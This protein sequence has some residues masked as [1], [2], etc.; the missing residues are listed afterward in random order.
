MKAR[1][2]ATLSLI[3]CLLAGAAQARDIFV[4]AELCEKYLEVVRTPIERVRSAKGAPIGEGASGKHYETDITLLGFPECQM[5][6]GRNEIHHLSCSKSFS[7]N[8]AAFDFMEAV[9]GCFTDSFTEVEMEYR[10]VGDRY[11]L[12]AFSGNILLDEPRAT[13]KAPK[14]NVVRL[15]VRMLFA[16][17]EEVSFIVYYKYK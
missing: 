3:G 16:W 12:N 15:W 11:R 9:V 2:V 6:V 13:L 10:W 7:G 5:T 8:A 1:R 17:R 4:N 14:G